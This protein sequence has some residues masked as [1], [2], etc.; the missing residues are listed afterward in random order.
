MMIIAVSVGLMTLFLALAFF[1]KPAAGPAE[2]RLQ[3]LASTPAEPAASG[4]SGTL[5]DDD[6][7][8]RAFISRLVA[9]FAGSGAR[10]GDD[11]IYASVRQRLIEAGFRRPSAL[12]VYMGSRVVLGSVLATVT[13]L[14]SWTLGR[15]PPLLVLGMTAAIGYILPGV[16]VDRMRSTRQ[17]AIQRGLAD[18]IDMMVVCVEAGLGLQATMSRVARELHDSEPIIAEEF[19]STVAETKAGRGLMTALRSMAKRTGNQDLNALVALLVQTERFGT[20]LIQTLR[21]QAESMRYERMQR[22][23]ETAQKAPVKMMIPA[24]LIF[25]AVILILAGPAAIN[26]GRTLPG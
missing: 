25:L 18:S 6:H 12:A 13:I 11:R 19:R 20:P 14:T 15:T 23:E 1:T 22:A 17:S 2:Q 24:A 7:S 21:T 5:L 8:T 16:I 26:I 10:E 9:R 3:R 4:D